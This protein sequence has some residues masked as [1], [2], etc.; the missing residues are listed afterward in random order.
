M[1]GDR[2]NRKTEYQSTT[3]RDL[4]SSDGWD[5]ILRTRQYSDESGGARNHSFRLYLSKLPGN[6][7]VRRMSDRVTIRSDGSHEVIDLGNSGATFAGL[8]ERFEPSPK[9]K[10]PHIAGHARIG[11]GEIPRGSPIAEPGSVIVPNGGRSRF[12]VRRT[13]SDGEPAKNGHPN[14]RSGRRTTRSP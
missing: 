8:G 13:A 9:E 14:S 6:R 5:I 2:I 7:T 10:R 12:G 11:I 1:G 4:R 3:D